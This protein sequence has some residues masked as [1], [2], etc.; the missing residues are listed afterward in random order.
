MIGLDNN[1]SFLGHWLFFFFFFWLFQTHFA[2]LLKI[3]IPGPLPQAC[4]LGQV[5]P[6][7]YKGLSSVVTFEMWLLQ[8]F[9]WT[10]ISLD[11]YFAA[12]KIDPFNYCIWLKKERKEKK[13]ATKNIKSLLCPF[14]KEKGKPT[15][16]ICIYVSPG[17]ISTVFEDIE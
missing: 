7:R 13:N 14:V 1:F 5:N 3:Y 10:S 8:Y 4:S 6:V 15:I 17:D 2:P 11:F 12:L 16:Y 9:Y